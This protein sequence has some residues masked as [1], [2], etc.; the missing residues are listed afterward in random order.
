MARRNQE[1]LRANQRGPENQEPV[2]SNEEIEKTKKEAREARARVA[3]DPETLQREK[4][5]LAAAYEGRTKRV[6]KAGVRAVTTTAKVGGA[7]ASATLVGTIVGIV[8]TVKEEVKMIFE[9]VAKELGAGDFLDAIKK[10]WR[11]F[12]P[13]KEG[14]E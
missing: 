12:M 6:A 4:E 3:Q 1:R 9:K 14:K 5:K 10:G 7:I 13:K 8:R 11:T 2:L